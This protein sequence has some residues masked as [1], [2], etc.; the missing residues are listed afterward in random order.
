MLEK[1][2]AEAPTGVTDFAESVAWGQF[3]FGSALAGRNSTGVNRCG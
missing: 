3:C 1:T 2:N